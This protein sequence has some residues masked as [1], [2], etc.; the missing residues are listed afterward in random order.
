MGYYVRIDKYISEA[1]QNPE[2]KS[3]LY[4]ILIYDK[5]I[6]PFNGKKRDYLIN[7]AGTSVYPSGR[8]SSPTSYYK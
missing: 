7:T 6:F 3:S 4:E 1:K 2:I 5:N 8:K